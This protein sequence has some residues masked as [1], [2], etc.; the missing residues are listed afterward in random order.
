MAHAKLA[1]TFPEMI[2]LTDALLGAH[3]SATL[4]HAEPCSDLM[5]HAF[6]ASR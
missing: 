4:A 1:S 3:L 6:P 5:F 2:A